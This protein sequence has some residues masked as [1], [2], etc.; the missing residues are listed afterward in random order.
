MKC[1]PSLSSHVCQFRAHP[2]REAI[3]YCSVCHICRDRKPSNDRFWLFVLLGVGAIAL[4]VSGLARF[5]VG[6]A[7]SPSRSIIHLTREF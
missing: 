1:P 4:V 5:N 3:E 2:L 6:N 7:N